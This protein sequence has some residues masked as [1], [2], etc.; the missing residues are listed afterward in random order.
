LLIGLSGC[1][2][3]KP[4]GGTP[5]GEG[6]RDKRTSRQQASGLGKDFTYDLTEFRK[7]DPKLIEY[8]EA[9]T[10]ETGLREPRGLAVDAQDKVYVAG[11]EA[12]LV[13]GSGGTRQAE[14]AVGGQPRCLA[15]AADGTLYVGMKD[16]VEVFDPKGARKAAWKSLGEK[17]V[18]TSIAASEGNVFVADAGNRVAVRYDPSGKPLGL[19]GKKDEKRNVPGFIIPSPHFDLAMGREGL[20]WVVNPGRHKLQAYTA[21]GDLEASW[22]KPSPAI[23]GFS[24]CCN[25]TDFALLPDGRFVTSEKV[26]PR[27]KVYTAEGHF[28]CVVAGPDQFS[29]QAEGLD[30][31]VD[32]KG[33][34]LVLDPAAKK[35]RIFTRKPK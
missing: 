23:E 30:L 19:I 15:V 4:S 18:L 26:L 32:S 11:D 34:I 29:K 17:A 27:V 22:G 13:F 14:L 3:E 33:R 31:A 25:P 12:V 24:G 8:D 5:G 21:D 7:V 16:H 1:S 20:L 2:S 10:I 9:G 28:E 6:P 35:V